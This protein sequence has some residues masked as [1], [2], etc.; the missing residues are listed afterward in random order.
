MEVL[1]IGADN[2]LGRALTSALAQYGRHNTVALSTSTCRWRSERQAKKAA[3]KFKPEFIVDLRLAWQSASSEESQPLDIERSHWIAKACER[4]DIGYLFLSRDQVFA[5][6]SAR[7]LRESDVP[8]PASE[9]GKLFATAEANALGMSKR[10]IVLRTGPIYANGDANF[11]A[12]MLRDMVNERTAT[13]D[14]VNVFCPV[15]EFDAARVVAAMLDQ[16]SVGADASGVFH[17]CSGDRT[18]AYGFAEVALAAASQYADCGDVTLTAGVA[19]AENHRLHH[20][21]DCSRLR[22]TFAIK[23]EAWRTFIGGAVRHF[24]E[25]PQ[26]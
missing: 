23:Q 6:H 8:D 18:T 9:T 7:N 15:A 14:D 16:L 5:G 21:L 19:G 26:A 12:F 13:F 1:L 24:F 2:A 10:G 20:V 3:R 25:P 17:Y 22:D 11:L 4:S